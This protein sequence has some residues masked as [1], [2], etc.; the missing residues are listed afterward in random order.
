MSSLYIFIGV[1]TGGDE[2]KASL[3][4]SAQKAG[5]LPYSNKNNPK[6]LLNLR[7]PEYLRKIM[8]NSKK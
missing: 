2:D 5:F 8:L 1:G 3:P 6:I 4:K 7:K